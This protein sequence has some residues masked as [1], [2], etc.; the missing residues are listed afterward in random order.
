MAAGLAQLLL[1]GG[2]PCAAAAEM[3]AAP[4]PV[5]RHSPV[6]WASGRF[7]T[8]VPTRGVP[9]GPLA[10]NGDLGLTLGGVV[11]PGSAIGSPGAGAQGLI[12]KNNQNASLG[13]LGLYLGKNDFW[14]WP[15][16]VTY[17]A[18]FQ[19]FSPGY[20]LAGLWPAGGGA[21]I[22]LPR[23]NGS[24]RL[25][26]GRLAAEASSSASGYA[27]SV[28]ASVLASQNTVLGSLTARCPAGVKEVG[29]KLTLSSDT[30]FAMPLESWA[31]ADG[32]LWLTKSNVLGGGLAAPVL[33]PCEP[34][35]IIYNSLRTFALGAGGALTARNAS[36]GPPLCLALEAGAGATR[37]VVSTACSAEGRA[38]VPWHR[39]RDYVVSAAA[40]DASAGAGWALGAAG[41]LSA[42]DAQGVR[43]C[44]TATNVS[45]DGGVTCPG[46][47]AVS[48][49]TDPSASGGCQSTSFVVNATRCPAAPGVGLPTTQHWGHDAKTGFLAATG[50]AGKCLAAVP[51]RP[52]NTL[53]LSLKL[54]GPHGPLRP[55][56]PAEGLTG[57]PAGAVT[58]CQFTV[59]CGLPLQLALGVA[60]E[61]DA[62]GVAPAALA[63]K[64][65]TVAAADVPRLM[66]AHGAWWA[67]WWNRSSVDLGEWRA[68]E[69]NYYTMSY[70][71]RGSMA[72]GKVAPALWGPWCITDFS[73]WSDQMTL[74]Y[75]FEANYWSAAT[76]NHPELVL[77]YAATILDTQL[78]PLAKQRASLKDWSHGGWPDQFGAEVM[79][80]PAGRHV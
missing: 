16:A 31:A 45:H 3:V 36:G 29:L 65:A 15:A 33:V 28:K 69:R 71:M 64:L 62:G 48:F 19:H 43:W 8:A 61:R 40:V 55:D 32:T 27:L 57:A 24:M 58:K 42:T 67:A 75:N 26:D 22:A 9:D 52:S 23:F 73:G 2:V 35:Q 37:A 72:V 56:P 11:V 7:P 59:Q 70:L 39:P 41:E 50:A 13:A 54:A 80:C 60:T 10:G 25:E 68:I 21:P 14:G 47:P 17:H 66:A 20:V 12:P 76:A 49:Y 63:E 51:P 44:L 38:G 74:D 79:V 4:H 46:G 5:S 53:A 78:V 34:D 6:V 30:I 18:S 1:L 77:S